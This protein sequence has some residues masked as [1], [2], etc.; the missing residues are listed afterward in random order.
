MG[1][2][3][4]GREGKEM[5]LENRRSKTS[6]E[7]YRKF[8]CWNVPSELL[9]V[10]PGYQAFESGHWLVISCGLHEEE[11]V[12]SVKQLLLAQSMTKGG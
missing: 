2:N 9:Q 3:T 8:R 7:A 10:G 4:G 12:T 5:E 6:V 1:I 11:A